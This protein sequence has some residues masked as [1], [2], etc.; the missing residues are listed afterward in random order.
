[1]A[2]DCTAKHAPVLHARLLTP[3]QYNNT[4]SDLVKVS[5]DLSKS[6]GGG[7]GAQ[8]DDLSVE[9]RA[10][11]ATSVAQQA[12]LAMAQWSPC[13]SPP[14]A[15]A[16]CEQQII[17]KV[18][19][20]VYRHP[21]SATERMELQV[22]FDAGVHEKDFATGGE[23]FLG[24]ILQSPDFLYQLSRP[25]AGEQAGQLVAIPSYEL[26]SRL[27]YFIWDSTPDDALYAAASANDLADAARLRSQ[28]D[29]MVKDA[30]FPDHLTSFPLQ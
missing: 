1:M 6:F 14:V 20:A 5:G 28:L 27:S 7:V 12:V 19:S 17:D 11:A 8:L 9:Q 26:A 18:G 3:S 30:R 10:N 24:G 2:T 29:R 22:L 21:L 23:W 13:M 25:Q 15:A 4:I 16:T